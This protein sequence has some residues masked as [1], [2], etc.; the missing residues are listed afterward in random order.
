MASE[1][2]KPWE[3]GGFKTPAQM[4]EIIIHHSG[5]SVYEWWEKKVPEM[6]ALIERARSNG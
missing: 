2:R 5:P 4:R 3:Y 1:P 6:L